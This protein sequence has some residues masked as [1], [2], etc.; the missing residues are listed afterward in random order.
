MVY[1]LDYLETFCEW[2]NMEVD[3]PMEHYDKLKK[4]TI[5]DTDV[6]LWPIP[7]KYVTTAIKSMQS[8]YIVWLLYDDT[9]VDS[10]DYVSKINVEITKNNKYQSISF[11]A[12]NHGDLTDENHVKID[13]DIPSDKKKLKE[14]LIYTEG[15]F[16]DYDT[17]RLLHKKKR[18]CC[19]I[20]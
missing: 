10:Y 6:Q 9:D 18:A 5:D 15:E 13:F 11:I 12:V 3:H 17:M 19:I 4:V 20:L 14:S 8:N 1:S 2:F 16:V 7:N